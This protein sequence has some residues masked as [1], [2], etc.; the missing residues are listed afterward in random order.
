MVSVEV[1]VT[2]ED[3]DGSETLELYVTNLP[4]GVY[5][6][7]Y[8]HVSNSTWKHTPEAEEV[9]VN[10]TAAEGYLYPIS[11]NLTVVSN[12]TSNGDKYEY[13]RTFDL[14]SCPEV[15]TPEDTRTAGSQGGVSTD[16]PGIS[17]MLFL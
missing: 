9:L 6:L 14:E 17:K 5:V 2:Q 10:V 13:T 4:D 15:T 3:T 16:S 1:T 12:E 7:N 11:F 8:S